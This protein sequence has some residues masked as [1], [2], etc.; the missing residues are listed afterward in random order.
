[1]AS[2]RAEVARLADQIT[3][4]APSSGAPRDEAP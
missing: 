1:V 2:L 4:L 3:R